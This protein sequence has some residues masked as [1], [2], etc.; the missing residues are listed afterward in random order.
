MEFG[1]G[2]NGALWKIGYAEVTAKDPV[3]IVE[4]D[5]VG[6]CVYRLDAEYHPTAEELG[7]DRERLAVIAFGEP[8][9]V[10]AELSRVRETYPEIA[11]IS[12]SVDV[13]EAMT[14]EE[15]EAWGPNWGFGWDFFWSDQPLAPVP[16]SESVRFIPSTEAAEV[17]DELEEIL[18]QANPITDALNNIDKLDWY[19]IDQEDGSPAAVVGTHVIDGPDG[20]SMVHFKGLGT[21]P[22]LRGRGYGSALMVGAINKALEEHDLIQ[23]G[24]WSWNDNA[25][26]MYGRV[27]IQHGG[28]IINGSPVPFPEITDEN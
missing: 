15:R 3:Y 16:G 25:R 11:R 18:L 27:G 13:L 2:A 8:E 12:T 23:F 7:H 20:I 26:R 1:T 14:P 19:V 17:R 4:N 24:M 28:G 6:V 5:S 10:L 21:L 22:E 9:A